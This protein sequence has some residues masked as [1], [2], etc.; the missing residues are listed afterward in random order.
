MFSCTTEVKEEKKK[1]ETV[2]ASPEEQKVEEETSS[3][4][5]G[6]H[7]N[8]SSVKAEIKDIESGLEEMEQ[9]LNNL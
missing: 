7:E 6:L 2:E 1:E 4:I 5:H 8:A 9:E 3:A